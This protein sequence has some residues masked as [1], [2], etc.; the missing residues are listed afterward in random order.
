MSELTTKKEA[1]EYHAMGR[2]G[3][4]EVVPTKSCLTQI[5]LSLAYSPGVAEPCREIAKDVSKVYDYTA[6]GN[7]VAVISDGTA[8]LGLG[9][10]GP[11]ASKP[12]MEGKGVLFKR[13]ADIDVFDIE[14]GTTD[15]DEIVMTVKNLEP[16]LAGVNLEDISAPRCFEIENRLKEIMDIPVFHDDQHGTALITGASLINACEIAGKKLEEIRLVVNGAGASAIACANFA[17]SLGVKH[18]HVLMCDSKGVLSKSRTNLNEFKM[19]YAADTDCVTLADA[20]VGADVFYGLSVGNV[21][22]PEMLLTMADSPIVFAM[23]NPDP[24]IPYPDAVAARDDVIMATGRSDYPNQC[25]NVL[26]F[27]FI[28]RGALDVRATTINT[29]MLH[30]AAYAL[31]DLAKDPVP[32]VVA[33]AY[34]HDTLDYGREYFI[35]KALDHRVI[36]RVA[37][38]VAKAAM[39]T[40]VARKTIELATYERELGERMGEERGLMSKVVARARRTESKIVYPE[41]EEDRI[42]I[43][44]NAVIKERIARPVL[45]GN[46][47]KIAAKAK[48]HDIDLNDIEIIDPA[49][50][51]LTQRY[52]NELWDA[53]RHR[54]L[55]KEEAAEKILDPMYFASVMTRLGDADGLVCG[56]TRKVRGTM[57]TLLKVL[58]LQKGVRRACGMTIVFSSKGPLFLTDT[59]VTIDPTAEDLAEF[60]ILAAKEVRHFGMEPVVAMISFSSYGGTPHPRSEKMRRAVEIAR[61]RDPELLVDGEMRL[62]AALDPAVA[63]SYPDSILGG[64]RAN[65]L[66]FSDL[67]SANNAFN[68]ARLVGDSAVVGPIM[69]GLEKPAHM[70]QPHSAGVSDVVHMTAIA[71]LDSDLAK[72]EAKAVLV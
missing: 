27:P 4:I 46:A 69:M 17:V 55:S 62:D 11:E 50:S 32:D 44:A 36:R 10:I 72:A 53:R 25:N 67:D 19:K 61:K 41:G 52:A 1:L 49:T 22:S 23:A 29:E 33:H 31:A 39:D 3:K 30:A 42:V 43:A 38:A 45:I 14:L 54:Q 66:V 40:G 60:A 57:P 58:P 7:L 63:A 2:P 70:L 18:E 71:C 64:K 15:V 26:G 34:G 24:E 20:M 28:F 68:M 59:S 21:V 13:F 16:T 48:E 9:N 8:V 56:V 12:V 5:D 51:D 47:E 65:I 35:P 37:T 6:K